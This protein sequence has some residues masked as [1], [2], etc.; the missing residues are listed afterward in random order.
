MPFED[1]VL[2]EVESMT[3][4]SCASPSSISSSTGLLTRKASDVFLDLQ[5]S[6]E[7]QEWTSATSEFD[8]V[9][10][11]PTGSAPPAKKRIVED[12]VAAV[13]VPGLAFPSSLYGNEDDLQFANH[14]ETGVL[15]GILV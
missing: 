15:D 5:S 1:A 14:S 4:R 7:G 12:H 2:P 11:L 6:G 3:A 13:R 9:D 8:D 10:V